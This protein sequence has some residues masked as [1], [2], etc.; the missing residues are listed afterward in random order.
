[1]GA[2]G[3]GCKGARGDSDPL[4]LCSLSPCS[5]L[6]VQTAFLGD[7]ILTLPL[8][9]RLAERFGPVDVVTTPA[10][11]PLVDGHPAVG[12]VIHYDKHGAERHRFPRVALRSA[13]HVQ[14]YLPHRSLRSALLALGI[15]E[16]RGFG[17]RFPALSYTQRH[18]W[19]ATGHVS[20]RIL[21]LLPGATLPPRPWLELSAEDRLTVGRWMSQRGVSDGFVALAPGS[22]WGT[23]RWPGYPALAAELPGQLVVIGDGADRPL[24]DEIVATAGGRAV[25][26]CGELTLRQSAALIAR[27]A[28]LITNDS[29]PLHLATALDHPVTAIFG[30][31]V[32]AFGFGPLGANGTIVEHPAMPCRPCSSHGPMV[33]PLGH[34]RCMTELS[35]EM[36]R[37]ER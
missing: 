30:P 8:I 34:H 4:H 18:P 21:S 23:K 9:I 3:Q 28:R 20:E 13:P 11:A 5:T 19:P 27:S 24:G 10:A 32:P 6:V 36:V 17:G 35:A 12:Q 1:M 37:G 31:T 14:A 26:A 33:C 29:A 22:R 2:R 7:L 25:N 16:R 15:R